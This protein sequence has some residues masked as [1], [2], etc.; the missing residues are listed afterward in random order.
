MSSHGGL[1]NYVELNRGHNLC[2]K[3]GGA[4]QPDVPISASPSVHRVKTVIFVVDWTNSLIEL[5]KFSF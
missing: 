2:E 1:F 5:V 4:I 3:M